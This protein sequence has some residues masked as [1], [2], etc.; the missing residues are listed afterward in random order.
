MTNVREARLNREVIE[1]TT[2]EDMQD[3]WHYWLMK[4]P[5][6]RLEALELLRQIHYGYD[7]VTTRL[8]RVPELIEP[9]WR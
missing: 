8:Q 7:P 6:E 1:V 4:T 5:A 3:D 2:F 9:A